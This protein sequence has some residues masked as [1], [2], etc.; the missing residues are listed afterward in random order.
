MG[1]LTVGQRGNRVII[2]GPV[3]HRFGQKGHDG[4]VNLGDAG[5]VGHHQPRSSAMRTSSNSARA[6]SSMHT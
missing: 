3:A 6:G 4:L 1:A 2:G 5:A